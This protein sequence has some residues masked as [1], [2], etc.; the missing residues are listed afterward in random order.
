MA[1]GKLIFVLG[2]LLMLV[3]CTSN[4]EKMQGQW[5]GHWVVGNGHWQ[6]YTNWNVVNDSIVIEFLPDEWSLNPDTRLFSFDT[7]LANSNFKFYADSVIIWSANDGSFSTGCEAC[8]K[9]ARG[10]YTDFPQQY[11]KTHMFGPYSVPVINKPIH[12]VENAVIDSFFYDSLPVFINKRP[13]LTLDSIEMD[14]TTLALHGSLG[15]TEDLHEWAQSIDG[16][17]FTSS[18]KHNGVLVFFVD[19]SVPMVEVDAILSQVYPKHAVNLAY[20]QAENASE[21]S[22]VPFRRFLPDEVVSMY[23]DTL[24]P[25]FDFR[26]DMKMSPVKTFGPLKYPVV[27]TT[28]YRVD[29][30]PIDV[31]MTKEGMFLESKAIKEE[32]LTEAI[33]S[34]A[35]STT[36]KKLVTVGYDNQVRYDEFLSLYILL[37]A[38]YSV[39]AYPLDAYRAFVPTFTIESY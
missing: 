35:C 10:R 26:P 38:H 6:N 28:E 13:F 37:R 39:H 24:L 32:A 11:L 30:C 8:F 7:I 25:Y 23:Y 3:A 17:F 20:L 9:L 22:M 15:S 27:Y 1:N 29:E 33:D 19:P 34:I 2:L 5:H 21:F 14:L 12:V 31:F 36:E 4:K 16:R 18:M